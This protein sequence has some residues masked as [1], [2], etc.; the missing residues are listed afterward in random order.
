MN[1]HCCHWVEVEAQVEVDME[2]AVVG[3]VNPSANDALSSS[4]AT[5]PSVSLVTD[6]SASTVGLIY[7]DN[8]VRVVL[9]DL[10]ELTEEGLLTENEASTLRLEF[11][12][13]R[14][15]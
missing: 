11:I 3:E 13:S 9:R 15:A 8:E 4:V 12:R 14:I 1:C 10:K 2:A 7:V 6:P 5:E